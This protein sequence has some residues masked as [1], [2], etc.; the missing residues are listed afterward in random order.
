MKQLNFEIELVS[1]IMECDDDKVKQ[2]LLIA[3]ALYRE[4]VLSDEIDKL[5]RKGA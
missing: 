3:L 2:G 5:N 4:C 1:E